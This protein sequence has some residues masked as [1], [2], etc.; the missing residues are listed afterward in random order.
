M[1]S[2]LCNMHN[3]VEHR[4]TDSDIRAELRRAIEHAGSLRKW[5]KG[6]DVSAT[7]VSQVL[8][9]DLPPGPKIASALGFQDDGRRWVRRGR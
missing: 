2:V 1:Y 6:A 4:Y 9:R 3:M 5:A 8:T 7:L